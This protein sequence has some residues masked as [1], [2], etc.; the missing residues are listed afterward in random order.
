LADALVA[1]EFDLKFLIRAITASKAYQLSSRQTDPAQADPRL[2][3]RMTLRGL[4]PHQAE[5]VFRQATGV[6]LEGE[7]LNR[8]LEIGRAAPRD[9]QTSILMAL[10]RMN[11]PAATAATSTSASPVLMAVADFPITTEQ[12]IESLYLATLSRFPSD[13]ERR[14]MQQ[15]VEQGGPRNNERQALADV[16]WV[17]LNSSEFLSNH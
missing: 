5:R 11:G 2:F 8:L 17:L 4:F 15:Y 14:R 1:E 9:Q 7:E 12:R 6:E 13:D 16:L 3:A 10:A